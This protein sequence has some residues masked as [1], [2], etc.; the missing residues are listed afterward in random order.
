[1]VWR[2]PPDLSL[3]TSAKGED[4]VFSLPQWFYKDETRV[5]GWNNLYFPNVG[6]P[7][8]LWE[9]QGIRVPTYEDKPD[10]ADHTKM[11]PTITGFV[12]ATA[13]KKD[14]AEYEVMTRD[15]TN[16]LYWAAEPDRSSRHM[17]GYFMMAFVIRACILGA[18]TQ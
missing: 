8:A 18:Q 17:I 11:I 3:I 1:M 16:F 15:I 9:E 10:P 7:H 13:G 4:Y 12:K 2:D 14:E 6:M 5:T